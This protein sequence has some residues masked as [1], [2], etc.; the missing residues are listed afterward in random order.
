MVLL[1]IIQLMAYL[2]MMLIIPPTIEKEEYEELTLGFI[3][4]MCPQ[5]TE[6]EALLMV[7]KSKIK[8][9]PPI[10]NEIWG[11]LDEAVRIALENNL[12]LPEHY[13]KNR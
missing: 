8:N 7:R 9:Y 2:K 3:T 13:L 10:G 5:V 6:K 1:T 4:M 12:E 11:C